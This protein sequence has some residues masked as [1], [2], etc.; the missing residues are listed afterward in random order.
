MVLDFHNILALRGKEF[1]TQQS[2]GR[3]LLL[4]IWVYISMHVIRDL[5]KNRLVCTRVD[6]QGMEQDG[7]GTE[8]AMST[9]EDPE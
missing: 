7:N 1:Y 6:E 8:M 3:N 9:S 2:F 5:Y 4:V